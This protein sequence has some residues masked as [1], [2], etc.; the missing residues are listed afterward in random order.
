MPSRIPTPNPTTQPSYPSSNPTRIP[1]SQPTSIP[2]RFPTPI[3][4]STP[5]V[6]P[7]RRPTP[8]PSSNPTRSPTQSPANDPAGFSMSISFFN[9]S[10]TD[11]ALIEEL[12]QRWEEVVVGDLDDV[13]GT[14]LVPL[15]PF[16]RDHCTY[17]D[18]IDDIHSEDNYLYFILHNSPCFGQFAVVS[19][20]RDLMERVESSDLG[21]RRDY[22]Q[23][24]CRLPELCFSIRL[25]LIHCLM[26]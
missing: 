23:M 21:V 4:T 18:V 3:P 11:K 22:D 12:A 7:T 25:I 24:G 6:Q 9:H 13:S 17:P 26:K 1:T 2:K 14:G 15:W 10:A 5:T 19:L 8:S 20:V 16:A